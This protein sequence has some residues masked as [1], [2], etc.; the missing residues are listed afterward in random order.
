[1]LSQGLIPTALAFNAKISNA[2]FVGGETVT[3]QVGAIAEVVEW[4]GNPR[5][6]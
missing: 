6:E 5:T 1:M 4:R 3:C 2:V